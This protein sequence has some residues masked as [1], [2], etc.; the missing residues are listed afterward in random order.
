MLSI[1]KCWIGKQMPP[2]AMQPSPHSHQEY[3]GRSYHSKVT[4]GGHAEVRDG[5][6]AAIAATGTLACA[7]WSTELMRFTIGY[8][9]MAVARSARPVPV[10]RFF[11]LGAPGRVMVTVLCG[12][13]T[14]P[15]WCD[16][17]S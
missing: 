11:M 5:A 14:L 16:S 1:L 15:T 3:A 12:E 9:T 7:V 13:L 17:R 10:D 8:A 4:D 6:D 2:V